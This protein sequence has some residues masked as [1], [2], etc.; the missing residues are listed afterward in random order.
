MVKKGEIVIVGPSVSVGYLGS[1]E[2]TEKS[3]YYD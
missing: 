1:P 2:L 3:I